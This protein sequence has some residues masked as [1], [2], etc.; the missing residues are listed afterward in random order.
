MTSQITAPSH[1]VITYYAD[2]DGWQVPRHMA[3]AL[4]VIY[5]AST[6]ILS[7]P[8]HVTRSYRFIWL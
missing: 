7:H 6:M 4:V 8:A 1:R 3:A 5:E 2:E